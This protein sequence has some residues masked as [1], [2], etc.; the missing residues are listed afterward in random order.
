MG[1]PINKVIENYDNLPYHFVITRNGRLK[2]GKELTSDNQTIE[3]AL[4]GGL[5]KSGKHCD[6]RTTEQS[7]ALFT[8]LSILTEVLPDAQIVGADQIYVY[9]HVNP[10]FDVKEWLNEYIP[11]FL[12]HADLN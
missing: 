6:T 12:Q 1:T 10:G 7:E 5:N 11:E 4:V 3:V 9:N 2:L 8:V